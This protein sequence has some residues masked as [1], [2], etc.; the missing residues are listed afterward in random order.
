MQIASGVG[1]GRMAITSRIAFTVGAIYLA[2]SLFIFRGVIASIPSVLRGEAVINGDELVPFFNPN[3]QFIEQAAGKFNQLTNGYEFRVRYSF[4]TTWLRYYKILPFAIVLVIPAVT[5]A[6]Y[7]AVSRFLV[8]SLPACAAPTIYIAAA[9]AVAV[10]F[11]ILTYAKITHFYTLILGFSLFLIASLLMTFGLIF[12]QRRPYRFIAAACII[13]LFNPAIHYLILFA[14]Y[15]SITVTSLLTLEAAKFIRAGG[16]RRLA[17]W[18]SYWDALRHWRIARRS[19]QPTCRRAR[20]GSLIGRSRV[21]WSRIGHTTLARCTLAFILLAA[22]TIV[23]YGLMVKFI[24]LRGVPNISETV[25]GDFYFISDASVPLGHMLSFD[26]AGIM[27]KIVSGDYLVKEPRWPN[28]TYTALTLLPLMLPGMRRSVFDSWP[29]RQFLVVAYVNVFFSMWATL[30]YSDPAWFPTFHR[31]IAAISRAADGMQSTL[32]NLILQLTSTIVQVLR[33]P[34]RFQL[35]LFMMSCVLMSISIAWLG[36]RLIRRVRRQSACG[37]YA[38]LTLIAVLC[39]TPLLSSAHYRDA[40]ASGNLRGFLAPY[41]VV[42]LKEVKTVLQRMPPGKVV[43]LP[44]TETAK[45]IVSPSGVEHKFIDKFHIYY[46]DLPSYYYG[47]TGDSDNKFE[48]FLLLRAL[49][50]GQDWWVNIARDLNIRYIV[51]NRELIASTVGGAEYLRELERVIEPQLA[52]LPMY[53]RKLYEND[54]YAVYEFIDLPRAARRPLLIDTSWSEFIRLL[55]NRLDLTRYYD[56]RHLVVSDDLADYA[57]L[58]LV[59][60]DPHMAALDLFIKANPGQFFIPSSR[61]FAFSPDI[62]PSSYYLSPMFRLFQFFSDS[63]WNRLNMITPGLYGTIKGSFIGL[64]RP[65]RFRIDA[66]FP[67]ERKYRLL[68]RGAATW[69]QLAI[70]AKSLGYATT[71]EL[72][73]APGL[74]DLYDQKTVFSAGRK[75]IDMEQ[76][77]VEEL[78]RLIPGDIVAINNRYRY[79]DLGTVDAAKGM[80]TFYFDK[81]DGNPLLVEGIL[82][83]PEEAYRNLKL[84]ENV[85]WVKSVK[86]LCCQTLPSNDVA[87]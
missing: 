52:Q 38:L 5:F 12:A 31:T 60:D 46:L 4:L 24:F 14:L 40:F 84:P 47:L 79:F 43:V 67:E 10:V 27:D 34:H 83:M 59:T 44:P 9:P 22:L 86:D 74:L 6:A 61:I 57:N 68:L 66:K 49:Y 77:T 73:A 71:A 13:T 1:V 15:L 63:K 50:Y 54:S 23:P 25:P 39:A 45:V 11:A 3:S 51:I 55:S 16:L 75:A 8:A 81:Q 72:R 69:N 42:Y 26:M 2:C 56:L 20:L 62:I 36:E 30:G 28:A 78:E 65:T 33:F 48:F 85:R 82:V 41:P 37:S 58:D 18:R 76:Y 35:I 19:R 70:R 17:N 29:R 64:P 7:L 21:L 80:H 32:G 53:L 87:P